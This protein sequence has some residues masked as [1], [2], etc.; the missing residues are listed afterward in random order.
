MTTRWHYRHSATL[1]GISP[2]IPSQPTVD[3]QVMPITIHVM[4]PDCLFPPVG[5]EV[6]IDL[7]HFLTFELGPSTDISAYSLQ[8]GLAGALCTNPLTPTLLLKQK[9]YW[10]EVN[11]LLA[12]WKNINDSRC[13]ECSWSICVNMAHHIRLCH[14]T[15]LCFWR[16]P[17]RTCPVWFSSEL[18]GKDHIERTHHFREGRGCSFYEYL[19]TYGLEWYG[20]RKSFDQ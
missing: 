5:S 17:V 8:P 11:P 2:L 3:Y 6:R 4:V 16:C 13:P 9:A 18:N 20:D 10:E 15:Y 1:T 19:R 14:T 7:R 12:S